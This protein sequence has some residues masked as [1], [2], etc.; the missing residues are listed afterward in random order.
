LKLVL[1]RVSQ[2]QVKVDDVIVG[3]IARG[4]LLLL[5]VENGDSEK[6]MG[7]AA[8]K[9]VEMRIFEDTAEKMN[10][11]VLDI[12]GQILVISQ[13]TLLADVQ[14]GRRPSFINAAEPRE[15]ERLYNYFIDEIEKYGIKTASGTFGA[16]MEVNLINDGPVTIILDQK[17]PTTLTK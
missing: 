15:A 14:K 9:V 11:S 12:N 13:F 10:L 17:P 7:W 6:E 2:A 3:Q 4:L 1:Q 8:R 16:K 5:G